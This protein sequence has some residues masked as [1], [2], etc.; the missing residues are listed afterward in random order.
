MDNTKGSSGPNQ[1][2][3]DLLSAARRIEIAA[4]QVYQSGVDWATFYRRVLGESGVVREVFSTAEQWEQFKRTPAYDRIQ[5]MLADLRRKADASG[6]KK[7][8]SSEGGAVGTES[9]RVHE[10]TQ[11]I[12]IRIP[13]SLHK[14]L[15]AEADELGTSMNQL[16]IS[17]LLQLVEQKLVPASKRERS[18]RGRS[19]S[20]DSKDGTDWLESL[21]T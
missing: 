21:V 20:A 17:K 3:F 14:G 9:H 4:E 11:M 8:R 6:K 16:C 15:L 5:E 7:S 10:P 12:T 13:A 19:T 2:Q 1:P 18:S